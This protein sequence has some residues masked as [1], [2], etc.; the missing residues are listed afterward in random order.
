MAGLKHFEAFQKP[1]LLGLVDESVKD[2]VPT[3]A[4]QFLPEV[5]VYSAEVAYNVI[6]TSQYIASY[7]GPGAE[8]PI[9]DRNEIAQVMR[10]D[11]GKMGIKHIVT[12]EEMLKL[13]E[14]RRTS[15]EQNSII[16]AITI[17][18][19]DLIDAVQRQI[20]AT[21]MRAL[22]FGTFE[23][24]KNGVKLA[25]DFGV[26][27][28]HKVALLPGADWNTA[29]RDKL[30]DLIAFAD[31]YE[32]TNGARPETMLMSRQTFSKL[33][34]DAVIIAEAGRSEGARRVS[35]AE[36][37][38]VLEANGLPKVTIVGVLKVVVKRFD[39]DETETIE[40]MPENRIV[41]LSQGV[42]EYLL[43]PTVEK[44]YEPGIVL[45]AKD[46]DEPIQSVLKA[47]AAG[48]PAVKNPYLIFHADVYT[49]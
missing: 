26:P 10:G 38:E 45:L 5:G 30:G 20:D 18:G 9:M 47:T 25:V 46:E 15:Q 28:E 17:K 1:A 44:D 37:N 19:V 49:P 29:G 48:F 35:E 7:V 23:H 36:V 8:F 31:Q 16:D 22:G 39:S 4:D 14:G 6:R 27:A 11:A 21:K 33:A 42:G 2:K 41:F 34:T 40:L 43:A 13:Q 12:E 3:I 24:R 32:V